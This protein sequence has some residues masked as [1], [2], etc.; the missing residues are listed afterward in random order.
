MIEIRDET[1][2]RYLEKRNKRNN[3]LA[4]N[5]LS[6]MFDDSNNSNADENDTG[7]KK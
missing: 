5:E 6:D 3:D 4:N 1:S 7:N 2:R